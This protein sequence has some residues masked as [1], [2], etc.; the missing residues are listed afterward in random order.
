MIKSITIKPETETASIMFFDHCDF[1]SLSNPRIVPLFGPNGSGKTTFINAIIKDSE[2]PKTS[3]FGNK[4]EKRS[5]IVTETDK[6]SV[7]YSYRN[8]HDNFRTREARSYTEAFNPVYLSAM[9][10]AQSLSEGQSIVYSLYDLFV[11]IGTGKE[12]IQ[13]EGKDLV[14]VI[15]ELDSG[16]SLDNLDMFM[17]KLKYSIARR[18]DVQVIFSFNNP[19]VLKYFPEVISMYDG[20]VH[21]LHDENDM[22]AEFEA[23]AAM[24]NKKRKRKDGRPKVPR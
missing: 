10:D 4:A 11:L 19:R 9:F 8:S 13:I 23:N 6:E 7:V 18:P 20:K 14:V 2:P 24:F 22:L 3:F 17:K 5:D 16:L 21:K 15:D 1:T 12:S